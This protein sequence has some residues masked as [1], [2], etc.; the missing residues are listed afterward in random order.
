MVSSA[1]V[2]DPRVDHSITLH[3]NG[4]C[5][6]SFDTHVCSC[7]TTC[8]SPDTLFVR[9]TRRCLQSTERAKRL[10]GPSDLYFRAGGSDKVCRRSA[11]QHI[12]CGQCPP[13]TV[14]VFQN[15]M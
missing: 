8:I 11:V 10:G 9:M 14:T 6:A 2:S 3:M 1:C 13:D 12:M 4:Q 15:I 7:A 5:V